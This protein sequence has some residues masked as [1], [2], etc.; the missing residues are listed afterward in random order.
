M[1]DSLRLLTY[2][3]VLH[4]NTVDGNPAEWKNPAGLPRQC[5]VCGYRPKGPFTPDAVLFGAARRR[6]ARHSDATRRIQ[7]EMT[8]TL[9]DDDAIGL[10]A[11]SITYSLLIWTILL[12]S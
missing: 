5:T 4:E 8:L 10:P 6:T 3:R 2:L 7:C 11:T 9:F 12:S 1:H